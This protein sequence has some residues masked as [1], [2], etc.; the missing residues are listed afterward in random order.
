MTRL[1]GSVYRTVERLTR[2]SKSTK[3]YIARFL[4]GRGIN[5][6]PREGGRSSGWRLLFEDMNR[7]VFLGTVVESSRYISV[8][9][10]VHYLMLR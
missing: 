10:N 3:G 7:G 1:I 2:M 9:F 6:A 4:D 8:Y 5:E